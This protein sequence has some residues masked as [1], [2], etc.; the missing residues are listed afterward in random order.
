MKGSGCDLIVLPELCLSG[1]LVESKLALA[2]VAEE[3]PGG[4]SVRAMEELSRQ[5]EDVYKRQTQW[6]GLEVLAKGASPTW[7]YSYSTTWDPALSSVEGL[8]IGWGNGPVEIRAG[9]GTVITVTEYA[10]RPLEEAEQLAVSSSG[11]VLKIRWDGSI[12]PL[13]LLQDWEKRLVVEVPQAVASQLEDCLLYTSCH[14]QHCR[15][16][17]DVPQLPGGH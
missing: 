5:E 14:W 9:Q 13:G 17:R 12:V 11:G 6:F 15:T 3:V 7:A 8:D 16:K 2:Q 10:S 1:Y 4:P